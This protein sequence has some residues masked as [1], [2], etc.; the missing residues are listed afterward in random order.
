MG[1]SNYCAELARTPQKV[2]RRAFMTKSLAQMEESAQHQSVHELKR[3]LGPVLLTVICLGQII[4][5]GI[6]VLTGAALCLPAVAQLRSASEDVSK[7]WD[8]PAR[9]TR[10]ALCRRRRTQHSWV[11]PARPPC[12]TSFCPQPV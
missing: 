10:G 8:L 4:G 5:S 6:F 9:L 2:R 7:C 11:T 1:F 12:C 3:V